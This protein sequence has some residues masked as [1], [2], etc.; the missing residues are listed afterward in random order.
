MSKYC[1]FRKVKNLIFTLRRGEKT[2]RRA[3][4]K[5]WT[6]LTEKM[7]SAIVNIIHDI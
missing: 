3:R 1:I 4:Y 6:M 7:L 2:T 5:T